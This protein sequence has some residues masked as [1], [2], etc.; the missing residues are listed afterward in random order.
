M[1]SFSHIN[2]NSITL[3]IEKALY[4]EFKS[5]EEIRSLNVKKV[6]ESIIKSDVSDI[7]LAPSAGY[8]YGDWGREKIE[9]VFARVFGGEDSLVRPQISTGTQALY[10]SLMG[11]LIPS[12]RK[13][14][15]D[16]LIL[17]GE[18]YPTILPTFNFLK[19]SGVNVNKAD[20]ST[21]PLEEILSKYESLD[22]IFIQRSKGYSLKNSLSISMIEEII[23]LIRIYYSS[24][25]II[26]VDNCYSEFVAVKEPGQIGADIIV[27]SL[28]KNP[29]GGIVSTGGY[30]VGKKDLVQ[31]IASFLYGAGVGKGL[32]PI[33]NKK[34][35]LLGLYLAPLVV[36]ESL[37]GVL[38]GSHL[39]HKLSM[40]VIP[41]PGEE[42]ADIVLA[43]ELGS[44]EK[45]LKALKEVQSMGPLNP[46]ALP[47]GSLLPGYSDEVAMAG[48]TFTPGSSIELS[49]D[50]LLTS[51]WVLYLQGSF[52]YELFRE[53]CL[54]IA[55][56]ILF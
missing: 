33:H 56:T 49:A 29:G 1:K 44:K 25:V 35:I 38:F 15:K 24:N 36:S 26:L 20:I 45:V 19:D 54:K 48:G 18:P 32:G 8:G 47:E 17:T 42:L 50:A 39:F 6:H 3:D 5:I 10:L 28:M 14:Q 12:K 13:K 2:L 31:D 37:K 43:V 34:E 55:Q 16:V 52:Y 9:E 11:T 23:R 53:T 22:L 4:S 51:P 7:D 27:G 46:S 41:K 30:I 40:K 21:T